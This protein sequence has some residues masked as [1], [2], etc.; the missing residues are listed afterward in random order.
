MFNQVRPINKSYC[1]QLLCEENYARLLYLAPTS[2]Q[3]NV[4][5][6]TIHT[7]TL[8]SGPFTRTLLIQANKHHTNDSHTFFKCRVYLDTKSVEVISIEG[9][10]L[11]TSQHP[12]KPRE[13]LNNKWTLN[14]IF[15]K[16]LAYQLC[17]VKS[18][19]PKS[20]AINA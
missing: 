18:S 13:L 7:Q 14:Y 19:Q 16:W 12:L 5:D 15:E 3:S 10:E 11:P 6:S 1:L 20:R 17:N 2:I 9:S 8:E 4:T